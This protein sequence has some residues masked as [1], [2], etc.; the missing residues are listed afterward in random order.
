[1]FSI[2]DIPFNILPAVYESL[3]SSNHCKH[4]VWVWSD[5]NF[6]HCFKGITV[7]HYGFICISSM[8][9]NVTHIFMCL[10]ANRPSSFVKCSNLL[11]IFRGWVVLLLL[12]FWISLYIL[13]TSPLPDTGFANIF[14]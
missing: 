11:L 14:S 5:F 13:Y 6:S 7:S 8:T 12:S 1:M 9:N 4:L 3:V 2:V 10:F